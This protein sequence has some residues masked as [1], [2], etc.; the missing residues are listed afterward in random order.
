MFAIKMFEESC[1]RRVQGPIVQHRKMRSQRGVST[2][3]RR[4]TT[5]NLRTHP[6][7]FCIT[8]GSHLPD[9]HSSG[10]AIFRYANRQRIPYKSTKY[11][12]R[13]YSSAAPSALASSP[14]VSAAAT[15]ASRSALLNL[16]TREYI[17]TSGSRIKLTITMGQDG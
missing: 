13:L 10:G 8:C 6:T 1:H 15:A 12:S 11:L 16:F 14:D 3:K 4:T 7:A 2:R 5:W 9:A 17:P